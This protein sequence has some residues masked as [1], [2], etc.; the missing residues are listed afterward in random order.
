MSSKSDILKYFSKYIEEQIGIIYSEANSFQLEHRLEDIAKALGFGGLDDLWRQAQGG[1][2][3]KFRELLLD[4]ATNNETSF[5]RDAAVF[6]AVT[7]FIVPE[8]TKRNLDKKNI[9]FWSAAGSTGQEAY[10]IAMSM[11]AARREDSAFPGYEIAVTDFSERVLAK[12]EKGIYSQLEVQRGLTDKHLTSFFD[13]EDDSHWRVK[14]ILRDR[15]RFRRQNLL[16]PFSSQLVGFDIV[17]C[18]NVLIYQSV[19]NK[20]SVIE[21]ISR[22]MNPDGY[23][24]LGAAESMLGIS[25]NF[26]QIQLGNAVAYQKIS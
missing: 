16:E 8:I 24:I 5:F 7:K 21:R 4:Q 2:S 3:G 15:M 9:F 23:L 20:I 11:E 12:A 6:E 18:R 13:K 17:F 14:S 1:I 10:S 25:N 19:E 22:C 26:K